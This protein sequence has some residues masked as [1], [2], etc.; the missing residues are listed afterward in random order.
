MTGPAVT[1]AG[2]P[3]RPETMPLDARQRDR[4]RR[5][6]RRRHATCPSCSNRRRWTVGDAL[7]LGFLFLDEAEDAYMV[8]LICGRRGCPRPRTGIVVRAGD[9]L[10]G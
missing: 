5:V 6:A 10:T 3:R 7:P 9:F 4:V 2:A 1:E 8:A